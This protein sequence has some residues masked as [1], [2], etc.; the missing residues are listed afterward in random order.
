MA[1]RSKKIVVI[2]IIEKLSDGNMSQ[3]DIASS[4]NVS[5]HQISTVNKIIQ[6][7]GYTIEDILEM[8]EK[9]I[10][11]IF[12]RDDYSEKN[13]NSKIEE[14]TMPDFEYFSDELL[15]TK[16]SYEL[17]YDEYVEM[18][19]LTGGK[20]YKITQFKFH[21]KKYLEKKEFSEI[22]N[23]FPGDEI[24]VDWVGDMAHW[25]HPVTEEVF[26]GWM[27]VGVLSFSG[28]AY[29]EVFENMKEASWIQ[30][31]V[32]MFEYFG[33]FT[34]VLVCDNLKTGVLRHPHDSRPQLQKDYESFGH[35]YGIS[36]VPARV[37]QPNDKPLAENTVKFVE[38]WIIKKL[39]NAQ[40]YTIKEYN[41]L[42]RKELDELNRR[43]F[44]KKNGS[45]RSIFEEYEQEY[46]TPLPPVPYRYYAVKP[47]AVQSNCAVQYNYNYYSVPYK[48]VRPRQKLKLHIYSDTLEV[49]DV[50]EENILC[51]HALAAKGVKN[52]YIYK[53]E[54]LWKGNSR[55][56]DWN[57]DRFKR[58]ARQIGPNTYRVIESLFET[59]PEQKYYNR[60]H[61]I[62]KMAEQYT[63]ARLEM[64]CEMA[65]V[66]YGKPT[67][68]QIRN[69]L[70]NNEDLAEAERRN[71]QRIK[72]TEK[73]FVRGADYYA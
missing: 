40:C 66:H 26:K 63:D 41:E 43:P 4:L 36:I 6:K 48:E 62:L 22:M 70:K 7:N 44:S 27:F 2:R 30:A 34:R 53:S 20:A 64:A 24:E 46:L 16:L 33:G 68:P 55:W 8:D 32:N 12:R 72:Q 37:L 69:I 29:A 45:R 35:H 21:M 47:A 52:A 17:M 25:T 58:W 11:Q 14:Y 61:A 59:P 13:E 42:V 73:S 54:H 10:D 15:K 31:H 65:I 3:R 39:R 1:K 50:K 18:C 71:N 67:S 49:W 9:Q 23:H 19:R 5:R 38:D 57:S 60:A 51:S 56:G 28:L